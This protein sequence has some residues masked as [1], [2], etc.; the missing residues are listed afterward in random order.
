MPKSIQP[1]I[2]TL[3]NEQCQRL[4][5]YLRRKTGSLQEA[6]DIAQN[7]FIRVQAASQKEPI[8]NPKAYLYQTASNIFIDVKRREVTHDNYLKER[9]PANS[10]IYSDTIGDQHQLGPERYVGAAD[11]LKKVERAIAGLPNQCRQAFLMHRVKGLPYQDIARILGVSV[12]SVEKYI[13]Q[14]LKQCRK[15]LAN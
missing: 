3:F 14:S 4:V 9:A 8:N 2:E 12:S 1:N 10:D 11:E 5:S 13:L 7:A 6:E 15:A